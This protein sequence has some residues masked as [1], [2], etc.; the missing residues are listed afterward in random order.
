MQKLR[1]AGYDADFYSLEAGVA[2]YVQGYL[3]T[4]DQ[5]A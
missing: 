3:N 1:D 2:D 5:F 4:P